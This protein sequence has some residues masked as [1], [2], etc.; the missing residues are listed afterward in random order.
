MLIIESFVLWN[1]LIK[2]GH[3]DL[4]DNHIMSVNVLYIYLHVCRYVY[5][6]KQ[7]CRVN[8]SYTN[9]LTLV[10]NS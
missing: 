2:M 4:N 1:L 8:R 5:T 6:S 7:F 10:N 9:L 3:S